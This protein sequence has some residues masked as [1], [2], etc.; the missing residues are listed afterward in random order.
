MPEADVVKTGINGLDEI[1]FGGFP[2]GNTILVS[3]AAGTGKTT[4]GVEFVYRGARQFHEPGMIVLFEVAPDKLVRDAALFGWDLREL[5]RDGR[6]KIVFTTRQVFQQELLQAD[7][8]LL[9]EAAEFGARRL[10][11]DG[12]VPLPEPNGG[13]SRDAFPLP[14]DG[15]LR[16]HPAAVLRLVATCVDAYAIGMP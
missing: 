1:L 8:V 13:D 15:A 10:F 7:S 12:L 6:L 11:V 3:G 16:S 5:E 2:R 9:A 14:S 4:L